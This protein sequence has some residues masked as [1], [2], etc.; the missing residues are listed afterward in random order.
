MCFRLCFRQLIDCIQHTQKEKQTCRHYFI[1]D[2]KVGFSGFQVIRSL[3]RVIHA[4]KALAEVHTV[5]SA[6]AASSS[7]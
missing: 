1:V 3:H 7:L 2:E 6:L 5:F 4:L